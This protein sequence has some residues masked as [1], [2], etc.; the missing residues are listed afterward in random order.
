MK[1]YLRTLA[2]LLPLVAACVDGDDPANP[3]LDAD[4]IGYSEPADR[5][6][7]CGNC[8]I[9][10]QAAWVQT[11]HS[12]A[13]ATLENIGMD[14]NPVCQ[15]CHTVSGWANQADDS[16]GF[17]AVGANAKHF[18]KDVQCESCHGPG[19]PHV[20]NPESTQPLTTI[21]ADTGATVG[22]AACHSGDHHPFVEEWRSS[23]HG[24]GTHVSTNPSCQGC[25][26]GEVALRRFDR[27]AKFI[28]MSGTPG[29]QIT[30]A[31][32]HD[33]HGRDNPA[34]LRLPINEPSL[35]NNLCMNC[36]QRNF[37][38]V[39]TSTRGAHSP[40]G[41]LLIGIAGWIPPDFNYD[42]TLAL[43]SHGSERNPRLCAG[44]HVESFTITDQ[45]T[46]QFQVSSTGH[47]FKAIPCVDAN[48][49]P[50]GAANC[51]DGERR[52]N[53]CTSSGC[54]ASGAIASGLRNL[55]RDQ[56]TTN[57]IDVMWKDKDNDG[58]LDP[59]PIDSGLLAQV[60][61]TTPGDFSATGAGATT[62]TVGEGVWFNV[63]LVKNADGSFGV[64]NPF[65]A[66]ALLLA[67]LQ[68]LR[69]RYTYLPAPPAG[70]Q[71]RMNRR[72]TMLGVRSR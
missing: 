7:T 12:Q 64:H 51:P 22:C 15:Q 63:D 66:E 69:D 67:S 38:P 4:F 27:D 9:S 17:F 68:A 48:G 37:A 35:E 62:L 13:F 30:C 36:H 71:A 29:Q 47:R 19:A 32:C 44:C 16:S 42:S 55:L 33:P 61:F 41:P 52:F 14:D 26:N 34:Q 6:T 54:H 40:Q 5:Q 10:K 65:Y 45:I 18:Y 43:S 2:I 58:Q 24:N 70:L 8:H 53:A 50:T 1:R 57:Y 56:L 59:L 60:R 3:T 25:H 28:E 21:F 46:G 49:V 72:A 20:L 31:V 39:M 11:A 23:A